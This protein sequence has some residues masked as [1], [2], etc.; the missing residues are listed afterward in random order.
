MVY[1]PTV[2]GKNK[3]T[4]QLLEVQDIESE[5]SSKAVLYDVISFAWFCS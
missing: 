1:S 2:V 5:R 4:P 3:T